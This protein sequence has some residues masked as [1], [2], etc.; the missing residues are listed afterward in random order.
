MMGLQ[1]LAFPSDLI[2]LY[3]KNNYFRYGYLF[4]LWSGF[5]ITDLIIIIVGILYHLYYHYQDI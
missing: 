2:Y 5:I 3:K 1:K 4:G